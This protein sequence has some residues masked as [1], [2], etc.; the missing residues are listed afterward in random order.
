VQW[1]A[2]FDQKAFHDFLTQRR[3]EAK[4]RRKNGV[5]QTLRLGIFAPL[6]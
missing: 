2:A 5:F 4:S 3:K 6:R 1:H